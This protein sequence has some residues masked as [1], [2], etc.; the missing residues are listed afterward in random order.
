M[1]RERRNYRSALSPQHLCE[2][3]DLFPKVA[4]YKYLAVR[5]KINAPSLFIYKTNIQPALYTHILYI[6]LLYGV[7]GFWGFEILCHLRFRVI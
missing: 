4:S 1:E 6:Y 5:S 3:E 7:L 2:S